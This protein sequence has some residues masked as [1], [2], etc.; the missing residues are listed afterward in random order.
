METN[1]RLYRSRDDR[2]IAGVCTGLAK[3]FN[4]DPTIVRLA[5]VLGF[6]LGVSATL[7][8]YLVMALVVP[9][10]PVS[11]PGQPVLPPED[12]PENLS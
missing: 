3:Y 12:H 1:K 4:V 10:E 6:F 7:W 11:M 8:V 9:E 5:F 2:M